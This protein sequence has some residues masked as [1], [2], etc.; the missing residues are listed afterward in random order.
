M[1]WQHHAYSRLTKAQYF[2]SPP[3]GAAAPWVADFYAPREPV[4][5][6]AD[7]RSRMKLRPSPSPP[8]PAPRGRAY[9]TPTRCS[10][11]C[12]IA[13]ALSARNAPPPSDDRTRAPPAVDGLADAA[14]GG[15]VARERDT[16]VVFTSDHAGLGEKG[17][18]HKNTLWAQETRVPFVIRVPPDARARARPARARAYAR[19]AALDVYPRERARGPPPPAALEKLR[20]ASHVAAL[21]ANASRAGA[22]PPRS[23]R[24]RRT[25]PSTARCPRVLLPRYNAVTTAEWRSAARPRAGAPRMKLSPCARR[26]PSPSSKVHRIRLGWAWELCVVVAPPSRRTSLGI[27]AR[28]LA[29]PRRYHLATDPGELANS[30]RRASSR[31]RRPPRPRSTQRSRGACGCTSQRCS[32]PG[33]LAAA[34][35]PPRDQRRR[36]AGRRGGRHDARRRVRAAAPGRTLAHAV[37]EPRTEHVRAAARPGRAR[38]ER[39]PSTSPPNPPP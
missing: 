10:P 29:P 23:A 11:R 12:E 22:A 39:P 20:G 26:R 24:R 31:A 2:R 5:T 28:S 30:S 34:P 27:G 4:P 1:Q 16:V 3:R 38:Y 13:R 21:A 14:A 37:E 33:A 36:A 7:A 35:P 15:G 19:P 9:G 18:Y 6:R 25:R 17:H 8:P 32:R